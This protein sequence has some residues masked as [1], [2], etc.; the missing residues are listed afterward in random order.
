MT[1]LVAAVMLIAIL[2][3]RP[4]WRFRPI[5]F[6]RPQF[7]TDATYLLT[8]YVGTAA[9][10]LAYVAAASQLVGRLGLPRLAALELPLWLSVVLAILA[11]DAG[12]YLAHWLL[13]RVDALWEFHKI[14][15]SSET[16]DWLATF[17]S[18]LV[19]QALR[20]LLAPL[21][22]VIAGMPLDVVALAGS[23]F[24]AW[25]VFNH[26]NLRAELRVLEPVLVTP[27]LHRLHHVPRTTE[28]NLGTVLT[29]WDRL[30]GT[31]V[32]AP[33]DTSPLGIPGEARP[34]PQ[35]WLRQLLEPSR[36]LIHGRRA[37]RQARLAEPV[38]R[39]FD[40]E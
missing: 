27:R 33:A 17:R 30:R 28:R 16:L 26:S 3:R 29:L 6:F 1:I 8:G 18:H 32:R 11:I 13:H 36:R 35:G 14:H 31:L 7:V 22:L 9:L 39:R 20:R 15:H 24:L 10:A 19:E 25:A 5:P 34:Y 38:Y 2:E 12:N 21:L 23:L 4:R 37:A 40:T